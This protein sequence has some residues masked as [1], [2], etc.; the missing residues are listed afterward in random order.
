MLQIEEEVGQ[1][2]GTLW[3]QVSAVMFTKNNLAANSEF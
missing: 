2:L 1:N 3:I